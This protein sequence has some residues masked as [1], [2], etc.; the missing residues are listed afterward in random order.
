V[1]RTAGRRRRG[2]RDYLNLRGQV[3]PIEQMTASINQNTENAK[4]TDD[5]A[6]KSSVEATEGG[7]R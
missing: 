4:V 7:R 6:T 2:R 3:L 1:H 5:M